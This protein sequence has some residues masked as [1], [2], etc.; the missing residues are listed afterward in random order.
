MARKRPYNGYGVEQLKAMLQRRDA[1]NLDNRLEM[2]HRGREI[3]R[4]K[5]IS[6]MLGECEVK[7]RIEGV[8][9][10]FEKRNEKRG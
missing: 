2:E 1:A 5:R 10:E 9:D 8:I 7:E 3:M 4:L 6:E